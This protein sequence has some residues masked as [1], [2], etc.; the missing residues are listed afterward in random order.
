MNT[1][2]R[3]ALADADMTP[4]HRVMIAHGLIL[5]VAGDG[6]VHYTGDDTE[7]MWAEAEAAEAAARRAAPAPAKVDT[8]LCVLPSH[9]YTNKDKRVAARSARR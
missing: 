4:T 3:T 8:G 9:D 7:A 6:S 1:A 2:T 5:T